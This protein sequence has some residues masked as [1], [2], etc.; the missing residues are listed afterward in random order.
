MP[1]FRKR[2]VVINAERFQTNAAPYAA[3]HVFFAHGRTYD[4]LFDRTG[5]YILIH[6]L[7]GQMRADWGDW[8]VMGVKGELYPVK[9]DIFDVTYEPVS[10]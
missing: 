5:P 7:E 8:I 10:E 4:V 3:P 6:T 2:P 9:P 1:Y